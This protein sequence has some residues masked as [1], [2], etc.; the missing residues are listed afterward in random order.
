VSS[1]TWKEG[2][3]DIT[4]EVN[5]ENS[6]KAFVA[7]KVYSA[8]VTLTPKTGYTFRA[9]GTTDDYA[10]AAFVTY[11]TTTSNTGAWTYTSAKA[12]PDATTDKVKAEFGTA[13]NGDSLVITLT[14][15]AL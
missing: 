4:A 13:N 10:S 1:I 5:A 15:A 11:H 3:A 9:N 14:W 2:D 7:S 12:Q 8:T 6:T